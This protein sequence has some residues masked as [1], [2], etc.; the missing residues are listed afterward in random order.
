MCGVEIYLER[1]YSS[2][3]STFDI[4]KYKGESSPLTMLYYPHALNS[5]RILGAMNSYP[6][7]GF[8]GFDLF[9]FAARESSL[10]NHHAVSCWQKLG[11]TTPVILSVW[12][13]ALLL[14]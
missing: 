9:S 13:W 3:D 1:V 8:D 6:L 10:L 12:N 5:K 2:L 7:W 11:I 4:V 14:Q